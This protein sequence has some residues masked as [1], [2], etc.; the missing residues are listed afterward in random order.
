[1]IRR[2]PLEICNPSPYL[3]RKNRIIMLAIKFSVNNNLFDIIII[4]I[5]IIIIK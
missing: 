2:M 1:M 5:I 4:I 3:K